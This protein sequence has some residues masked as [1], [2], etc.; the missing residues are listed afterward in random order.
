MRSEARRGHEDQ[1]VHEARSA[2]CT[3][4]SEWLKSDYDMNYLVWIHY[5]AEICQRSSEAGRGES[6]IVKNLCMVLK[7]TCIATPLWRHND[8]SVTKSTQNMNANV[9][10]WEIFLIARF[11]NYV[12]IVF[13][14]INEIQIRILAQFWKRITFWIIASFY[15]SQFQADDKLTIKKNSFEIIS[16][17]ST[18]WSSLL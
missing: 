8:F 7:V 4:L 6:C 11:V 13:N 1:S 16:T 15:V 12:L 10:K 9:F 2:E 14:E 5:E 18:Y 17:D 3:D